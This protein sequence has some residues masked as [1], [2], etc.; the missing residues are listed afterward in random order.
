MIAKMTIQ[1]ASKVLGITVD[2][3]RKRIQ[4]K[5]IKARK[6]K[7]GRW[8]V[9]ID[10]TEVEDEYKD[11]NKKTT[12]EDNDSLVQSMKEQIESLNKQ[13]EYLQQQIEI[14]QQANERK[15]SIIMSLTNKIP[16]LQAPRE[17]TSIFKKVFRHEKKER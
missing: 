12:S 6:N 14:L 2:A 5:T 11:D 10:L 7:Q 8:I 17:R 15:D 1:D 13:T 16:V 9:A 4:R 3:I